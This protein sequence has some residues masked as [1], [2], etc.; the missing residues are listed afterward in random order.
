MTK[1][2]L[3]TFCNQWAQGGNPRIIVSQ[4][5]KNIFDFVTIAGQYSKRF[6][7][8]SFTRR[9]SGFYGSG[10][11]W[12]LRTSRWG[13]KFTHALMNDTGKLRNFIKGDA[14]KTN[15]TGW[16]ND[17]KRIFTRGA[18][19]KITT[20]EEST[21]ES[22]KRGKHQKGGVYARYGGVHNADPNKTNYTVNQ[23]SKRRP[24]R[25]QFIGISDKLNNDVSKFIHILFRGFPT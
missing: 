6:F 11:S 16:K 12:A 1:I 20:N 18:I 25:R 10:S 24:V 17:G 3:D 9:T 15:R 2:S 8:A 5:D 14:K 13:K 23:Y 22:K 4:L 21:P 19:Y 7:V